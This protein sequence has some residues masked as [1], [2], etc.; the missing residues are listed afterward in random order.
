MYKRQGDIVEVHDKFFLVDKEA[1]FEVYAPPAS[2]VIRVKGDISA[3]YLY[4]YLT[5]KIAWRIRSV[6]TIP[7][8]D[9]SRA[10]S[11]RLDEFP[12]VLP[13]EPNEVYLERFQKLS[14]PDERVYQKIVAPEDP[15][16]INE[17]LQ[18]EIIET[19]KLNNEALLKSQIQNDIQ[20]LNSCY[21]AKAYKSTIMMVGSILEAFLI[22]WLSE[23]DGVDYFEEDLIVQ[24]KN[25][26][27]G[28]ADLYGYISEI[29]NRLYPNW[30]NEASKAH[31]IRVKRNLV[32]AKLCLKRTEEITDDLCAELIEGL[33]IIINSR[34][35]L[36]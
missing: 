31:A 14:T 13:K 25:G 24:K 30:N 34:D 26:T 19:I 7:S 22:D 10:S 2:R 27:D 4:L 1:D 15:K 28:P 23:M 17:I 16:T 29:K 33:K 5:S 3:E 9:H 6:L 21:E 18:S 8:G 11:R 35:Q 32:H 36:P 20:E 12:I